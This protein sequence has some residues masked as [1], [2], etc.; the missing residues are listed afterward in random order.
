[1]E[2]IVYDTA[3]RPV[4]N[5]D[6]FDSLIWTD[7]YFKHGDFELF[8]PVNSEM[9]S[10]LQEDFYITIKDSEHVMIIE[11]IDLK[12]DIEEGN[13]FSVTG[14][15]LESILTRRI[16][17]DQTLLSGNF[18]EAI[19]TILDK[20]AISPTDLDRQITRLIFEYSTDEN[21]TLLSVDAQVH[22]ATLYDTIS[23][24][25][26]S[27][28]IGFKITISDTG[29]FVFKLYSGADRSFSQLEN[30]FVSFSPDLENLTNT[31]YYHSKI[32]YKSI[33]LVAGEG[34]G[35]SR[36]T[37]AVPNPNGA[38]ADL[39]RR[40]IFTDASDISKTTSGGTLTNEQYLTYLTER[41]LISLAESLPITAFDGKIDVFNSNFI[42][43]QDYFLGDIVQIANEYG[44]TGRSRVEEVVF[45]QD[46][47][48][49]DIYP[50]FITVE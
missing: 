6:V 12:T 1:M 17:W 13:K 15:S 42:Y 9:I 7:R 39:D 36:Q 19:K 50:T 43:G 29:Q 28:A 37:I 23:Q 24:L 33:T 4:K 2:L 49:I 32:P 11:S 18:Q 27:R 20:N 25:C 21:V 45:S 46:P 35:T 40:E 47:A 38:G 31:D 41:G 22:G 48:G 8:V 16:V 26:E 30:P 14:R 3:L 34:E 5:I 44:L 10:V